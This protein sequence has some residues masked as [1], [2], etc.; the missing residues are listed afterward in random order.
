MSDFSISEFLY[1][2][3]GCFFFFKQKTAYE[4]RISD[5]SSDVCSSDLL[6]LREI[7]YRVLT[8][9]LG[10][11]LRQLCEVDGPSQRVAR[12]IDLVKAR[13][14]EALRVEELAAAAHMSP[15]ALH[16]RFKAAT[17]MSPL[18]FQ[19]QLRLQE[20]R[21]LVLSAGMEDRKGK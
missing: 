10:G 4:M 7:Q 14:A 12:A 18:Q 8:G 20:A 6:A 11:R 9:E 3:V 19:K 15:S 17:T 5:W 13:Y 1:S 2:V 16:Q 21:R